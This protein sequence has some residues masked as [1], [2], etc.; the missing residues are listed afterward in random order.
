MSNINGASVFLE[1]DDPADFREKLI[2]IRAM[3][4]DYDTH[5][6]RKR[7]TELSPSAQVTVDW[8]NALIGRL[9]AYLEPFQIDKVEPANEQFWQEVDGY[10]RRSSAHYIVDEHGI[11]PHPN[12]AEMVG[13]WGPKTREAF[14]Q[15]Y[16]PEEGASL[17]AEPVW[18]RCKK[19]GNYEISDIGDVRNHWTKKLVEAYFDDWHIEEVLELHDNDGH[20]RKVT[21]R[22]LI[23]ERDG[24]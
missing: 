8:A 6:R 15:Y 3:V 21:L 12:L 19:F 16:R 9:D 20:P 7:A 13:S 18:T 17:F 1:I 5:R 24:E 22:E 2:Q 11:T 14:S 4:E 10:P 23:Q